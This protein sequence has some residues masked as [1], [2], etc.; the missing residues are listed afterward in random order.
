MPAAEDEI[1]F[2]CLEG[3][4][5]G[6][7][8]GDAFGIGPFENDLEAE[9]AR[10]ILGALHDHFGK[11]G[12]FVC[13][14]HLFIVG[15]NFLYHMQGTLVIAGGRAYG[16][17]DVFETLL[18][19]LVVG[20]AVIHVEHFPAFGDGRPAQR[21]PG[22]V[23]RENDIHLVDR[24]QSTDEAGDLFLGRLTI[25]VLVFERDLFAAYA[26]PAI[27]PVDPIDASLDS[28]DRLLPGLGILSGKAGG[29]TDNDTVGGQCI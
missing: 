24:D 10:F 17:D 16:L 14:R 28:A 4:E 19:N 2:G 25:V 26:H 18:E 1:G 9:F 29:V 21:Q 8:V 27:G 6:R 5:Q 13:E 15:R 20:P 23:W 12:V 11:F 3:R 22:A 7:Q